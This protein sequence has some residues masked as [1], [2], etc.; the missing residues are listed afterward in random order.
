MTG[1]PN[2]LENRKHKDEPG[3]LY[4]VLEQGEQVAGEALKK[5]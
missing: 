2:S 3:I 1:L 5:Q 4:L